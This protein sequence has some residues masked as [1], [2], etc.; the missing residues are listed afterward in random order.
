AEAY[1]KEVRLL[2]YLWDM[3]SSDVQKGKLT[4]R[5]KRQKETA[6]DYQDTYKTLEKAEAIAL[7]NHK[8]SLLMPKGLQ[9]LREG[10]KSE[11]FQFDS[12]IGAKTANALL[13]WM[14][15]QG[16]SSSE[17]MS[18]GV[19]A[20]ARAGKTAQGAIASYQEFQQ[21]ALEVYDQLNRDYNLD[22][23]VPIYR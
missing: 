10:L 7:S 18:N 6:K 20:P 3:G 23:L 22:N 11:K 17:A 5:L 1:A 9:R 4:E 15:Q 21:V 2:L 16:T 8:V 13:R 12:V 14:R 19:A